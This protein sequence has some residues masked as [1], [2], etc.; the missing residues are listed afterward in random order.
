MRLTFSAL[1]FELD[2]TLGKADDADE[3]P[4]YSAEVGTLVGFSPNV[5]PQWDADGSYHQ[6]EP[7]DRRR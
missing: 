6:F 5:A 1:G 2:V 4:R 7:E 3:R